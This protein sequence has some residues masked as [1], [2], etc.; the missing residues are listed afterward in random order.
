MGGHGVRAFHDHRNDAVMPSRE[1]IGAIM[2]DI[3]P[4]PEFACPSAGLS[5]PCGVCRFSMFIRVDG[6]LFKSAFI[7]RGITGNI[8]HEK[9]GL[10]E[11]RQGFLSWDPVRP[12][13]GVLVVRPP[14]SVISP[15]RPGNAIVIWCFGARD[16]II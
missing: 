3:F 6:Y 8:A 16:S 13:R 15:G 11:S 1:I 2:F 7:I 4:I 9:I 5:L 10:Y 14:P 12:V